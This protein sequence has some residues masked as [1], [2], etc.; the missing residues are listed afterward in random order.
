MI[1][2]EPLLHQLREVH[3]YACNVKRMIKSNFVRKIFI[4]WKEVGSKRLI[5][6]LFFWIEYLFLLLLSR[7]LLCSKFAV[8]DV[9][10]RIHRKVQLKYM[11][12]DCV[13]KRK[14]KKRANRKLYDFWKFQDNFRL[15]P[16]I[17]ANNFVVTN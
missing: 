9:V 5:E 17:L 1:R 14:Y 15:W 2:M 16:L 3:L 12:S 13:S 10:C 4:S 7:L 6:Y 8:L 11:L